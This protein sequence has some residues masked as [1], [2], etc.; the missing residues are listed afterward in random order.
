MALTWI[1]CLTIPAE[2]AL[3]CFALMRLFDYVHPGYKKKKVRKPKH[4]RSFP[5]DM[6]IWKL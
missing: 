6:M 5:R 4:R 3:L 2:M 1:I